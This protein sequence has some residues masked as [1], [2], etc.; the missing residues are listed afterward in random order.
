[1]IEAFLSFK[2]SRTMRINRLSNFLLINSRSSL[3][4]FKTVENFYD[5]NRVAYE[6]KHKKPQD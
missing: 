4:F 5:Q 6:Q 2:K 1:M 3:C